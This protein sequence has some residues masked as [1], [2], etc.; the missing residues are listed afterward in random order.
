VSAALGEE[1]LED[2]GAVGGEDAGG[3][4]HLM[5]EARVR[6]DF[7]TGA[8]G[9]TFGIV[10]AVD[11]VRDAGLDDGAGAHAA[12]LDGDVQSGVGEAVVA[13]K[14]G[15][16]AKND[17]FGVGSG[18]A[19]ADG[20]VARASEDLT[21]VDKHRSNRHFAGFGGRTS[22]GKRG[23][24][25]LDV[26]LHRER[27][28]ITRGRKTR[29]NTDDEHNPEVAK[30][31]NAIDRSTRTKCSSQSTTLRLRLLRTTRQR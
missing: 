12:R 9:A 21:V 2:G 6:K 30:R 8:N 20:V 16:F 11:E 14:A 23:L 19:V 28:N 3:D 18:V 25:E 10:G 5:V 13:E 27:E 24:H 4:L 29:I 22:F 26:L 17:D 31:E 15:G 1:R 7:E